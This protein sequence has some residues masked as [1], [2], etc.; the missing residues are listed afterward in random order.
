MDIAVARR[1][2]QPPPTAGGEGERMVG[3]DGAVGAGRRDI[4]SGLARDGVARLDVAP[5]EI[6]LWRGRARG[7]ARL[8]DEVAVILPL[9]GKAAK[10]R[11]CFDTL[12]T[13]IL[14]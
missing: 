4:F 8:V 1:Q 6:E 14:C 10:S 13:G 2:P 12:G 5:V 7:Q 3:D 11:P 9:R